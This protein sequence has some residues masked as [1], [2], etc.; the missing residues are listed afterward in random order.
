M[1]RPRW[2]R[3][4][5]VLLMVCLLS[6]AAYGKPSAHIL[7]NTQTS[8]H[9]NTEKPLVI[10]VTTVSNTKDTIAQGND[11]NINKDGIV[12]LGVEM[13]RTPST[14]DT[15]H[16]FDSSTM[17]YVIEPELTS[18]VSELLLS[19]N[20]IDL[21]GEEL[22]LETFTESFTKPQSPTPFTEWETTMVQSEEINYSYEIT[23]ASSTILQSDLYTED[24]H[25]YDVNSAEWSTTSYPPMTT[26]SEV[27]IEERGSKKT[28]DELF[29]SIVDLKAAFNRSANYEHEMQLAKE[30]LLPTDLKNIV[31]DSSNE[32]E[33]EKLKNNFSKGTQSPVT[34]ISEFN[35]ENHIAIGL[36]NIRRSN[37]NL[38]DEK[39]I[40]KLLT[41][42]FIN[43]DTFYMASD[44][45][46]EF[47]SNFTKNEN[48]SITHS[49]DRNFTTHDM[50]PEVDLGKNNIEPTF[51]DLYRKEV[52]NFDTLKN[53]E[54][55]FHADKF[56][57]FF[58][59]SLEDLIASDSK[60][61]HVFRP[62]RTSP[63]RRKHSKHSQ[64]NDARHFKSRS[65]QTQ[66]KENAS[67]RERSDEQTLLYH[68]HQNSFPDLQNPL[69]N[70]SIKTDQYNQPY[71]V[72]PKN[73]NSNFKTQQ[74]RQAWRGT[75]AKEF[76]QRKSKNE[77][78]LD[79]SSYRDKNNNS[80]YEFSYSVDDS[81]K[82][83]H[84][85][86]AEERTGPITNGKYSVLLPD[87][88]LQTVTY[89]A[90]DGGYRATVTYKE[91]NDHK[92]PSNVNN[93]FHSYDKM[94][95]LHKF[96]KNTYNTDSIERENSQRSH[97]DHGD[98]NQHYLVDVNKNQGNFIS[99][100]PQPR[101]MDHQTEFLTNPQ[102][103]HSGNHK[104]ISTITAETGRP[105]I[106][107]HHSNRGSSNPLIDYPIRFPQKE[108][109]KQNIHEH[110]IQNF[111]SNRTKF[112]NNFKPLNDYTKVD[113]LFNGQDSAKEN[114]DKS[115]FSIPDK[116]STPA[117]FHPSLLAVGGSKK[118]W[119]VFLRQNEK[120]TT[121]QML[122]DSNFGEKQ[123][124]TSSNSSQTKEQRQTSHAV[125]YI[126][127]N[128]NDFQSS[129]VKRNATHINH[130]HNSSIY[131]ETKRTDAY[132]RENNQFNI[133]ENDD[134]EVVKGIEERSPYLP[135]FHIIKNTESSEINHKSVN[136]DDALANIELFNEK[137]MLAS[138]K[139][140]NDEYLSLLN[141]DLSLFALLHSFEPNEREK[142]ATAIDPKVYLKPKHYSELP[143]M[144]DN[145]SSTTNVLIE[146]PENVH[147]DGNS[148]LLGKQWLSAPS[149]RDYQEI[150]KA[151]HS[152]VNPL[153]IT[154]SNSI[155][156][157]G[158]NI[159]RKTD[160]QPNRNYSSD[161][162][163]TATKE[164]NSLEID[165][166]DT[167]I[168]QDLEL[169]LKIPLNNSEY[170][171]FHKNIYTSD[172][173]IGDF[174]EQKYDEND[175]LVD[176]KIQQVRNLANFQKGEDRD[177]LKTTENTRYVTNP[178]FLSDVKPTAKDNIPTTQVST[179]T[180]VVDQQD[181]KDAPNLSDD[182]TS[183]LKKAEN[184]ANYTEKISN[185]TIAQRHSSLPQNS[186]FKNEGIMIFN[187]EEELSGDDS[188]LI[189]QFI[190]FLN[191]DMA[192]VMQNKTSN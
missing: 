117:I 29:E 184:H 23:E 53:V 122:H 26:D 123:I 175:T 42:K 75:N 16:D 118:L 54:D 132:E 87:G 82:G 190:L 116:V 86:H 15:D 105:N 34:N 13:E 98:V 77:K 51:D 108:F 120:K 142:F 85:S 80:N 71:L 55:P 17:V 182:D 10:G 183:I 167:I 61:S 128:S 63:R 92:Q 47:A 4:G 131:N 76:L 171:N 106:Q 187:E 174:F 107:T 115:I 137:L 162:V 94:Q 14:N 180:S 67:I 139:D 36:A 78:P 27:L 113:N 90:D 41:Q 39:P 66:V 44:N 153:V 100:Q 169:Q 160:V 74:F 58:T 62:S 125:Y 19:E 149:G 103:H 102:S 172:S 192:P 2:R 43:N 81:S 155:P 136:E 38:A 138:N 65:R 173:K 157:S 97:Q 181:E 69:I 145:Y 146:M 114:G 186:P 50:L 127:S 11:A 191:R 21:S 57:T 91:G 119:S 64:T 46:H 189:S 154:Q 164:P 109:G 159:I 178:L 3:S 35:Y 161:A 40:A 33:Q 79:R 111:E 135:E 177:F 143:K 170:T 45:Q 18:Q 165:S 129:I 70:Y 151:S 112:Q 141:S 6:S 9:N 7:I 84:F 176:E 28:M 12:E 163:L 110:E 48:Y 133:V 101:L 8:A 56:A 88:R 121:E 179:V 59:N 37:D 166:S 99:P 126:P 130:N 31:N 185:R 68:P 148:K 104:A 5:V 20:I 188:L 72:P 124:K 25:E 150:Y 83:N 158:K 156:R 24:F 1:E 95:T 96:S 140:S 49:H 22:E 73:L 60:V 134:N 168:K 32:V 144:S 89:V 147:G 52:V 93:P 152:F 30:N